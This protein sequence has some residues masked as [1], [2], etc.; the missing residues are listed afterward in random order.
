VIYEKS[1]RG[2]AN[3]WLKATVRPER[4]AAASA[5]AR[6]LITHRA[7]YAA[8]AHDIGCPWW[9]VA[10]PHHMESGGDWKTYLGNGQALTRVTT[11]A[12]IGRGPFVSFEAGAVDALKLKGWHR[13][14]GWELPRCLYELERFNGFGYVSRGIN[15]PYLWSFTTLYTRGKYVVDGKYDASAV[16]SQCGAAA[17]LK[18]LVA[19]GEVS[20]EKENSVTDLASAITPFAGLVPNLVRAIAGPLPSL[21]VRALAEALSVA[22]DAA[23]VKAK[24]EETPLSDLVSA[25]QR[26]EELVQMLSPPE[27]VSQPMRAEEPVQVA[28]PAAVAAQV[29]AGPVVVQPVKPEPT[30][31]DTLT[32]GWLT[33]WKTIAGI[34][35]YCGAHAAGALGYIDAPTAEAIGTLGGGLAGIGVIAK[36]ERWLPLFAGFLRVR[37][38][39][40]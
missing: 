24:L 14:E 13:I 21:A 38:T 27:P 4:V 23:P 16:S 35:V 9:M 31:L 25:L 7:R 19:L 28:A 3:L 18:A 15:S 2:Y 17:I 40:V 26:A 34:V 36:V 5:I 39:L 1:K 20:F 6:R 29:N 11:I 30:K 22:A 32:G 37:K 10:L 12:P 33:G 8:V